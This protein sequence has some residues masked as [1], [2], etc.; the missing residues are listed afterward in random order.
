MVKKTGD[1]IEEKVKV[2]VSLTEK[3]ILGA[4]VLIILSF[5]LSLLF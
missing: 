3:V 4:L 1:I 5:I 2:P